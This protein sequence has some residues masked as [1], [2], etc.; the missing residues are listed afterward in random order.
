MDRI[1]HE[2]KAYVTVAV[3]KYVICEGCAFLDDKV[4]PYRCKGV[5]IPHITCFTDGFG[6]NIWVEEEEK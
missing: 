1:E 2:G 4:S 6:S 3:N 5:D